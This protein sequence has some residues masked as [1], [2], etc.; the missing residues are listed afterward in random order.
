MWGNRPLNALLNEERA[1]RKSREP[2]EIL[3]KTSWSSAALVF[4]FIDSRNPETKD[5]E[6]HWYQKTSGIEIATTGYLLN[7]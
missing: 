4:G 2:R 7:G 1:S 3:L 6:K 5:V